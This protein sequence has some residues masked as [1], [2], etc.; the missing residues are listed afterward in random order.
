MKNP[1][2]FIWFLTLLMVS[3]G[4]TEQNASIVMKSELSIK[5]KGEQSEEGSID[6]PLIG[7]WTNC[8]TSYNG[9]TTTANVC[10]KIEFHN[11]LTGIIILVRLPGHL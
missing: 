6:N 2:Y 9:T 11:D 3:C 7:V 5:E 1:T 4:Q 8:A 10:K